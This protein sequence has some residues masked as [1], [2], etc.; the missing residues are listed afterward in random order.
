MAGILPRVGG[1]LLRRPRLRFALVAATAVVLVGGGIAAARLIGT[2]SRP[3]ASGGSDL[4][5]AVAHIGQG[6]LQ[7][8]QQVSGTVGYQGSYTIQTQ[9]SGVFTGLP[10]AGQVI[11]SGEVLYSVGS[12]SSATEAALLSAEAQLAS[13]QASL[14]QAL[15]PTAA[16]QA[17]LQA[18][19]QRVAADR[20]NI[21]NGPQAI[22]SQNDKIVADQQR[23]ATDQQDIKDLGVTSPVSGTVSVVDVSSGQQVAPGAALFQ[24]VQP[25]SIEVQ[26]SVPEIDLPN[27]YV[28]EGVE[29][30]TQDQGT[31]N[32]AVASIGFTSSGSNR[33]GALFPVT[34]TIE[35]PPS[36]M[37]AG[38]QATVSFTQSYLTEA[39]TVAFQDTQTVTAQVS[40]TVTGVLRQAGQAVQEG[41]SV[42]TLSSPQLQTQLTQ[43]ETQLSSDEAQLAS[44]RAQVTTY[45]A[46]LSSDQASLDTLE[47]PTPPSQDQVAALRARVSADQASV[48]QAQANLAQSDTPVVLLYGQTPAYRDLAQGESGQDVEELNA[49]LAADGYLSAASVTDTYG[50]ATAA[51]VRR[52]QAHLRAPQTGTLSLGDVVFLPNAVRVTTVTPSLGAAAGN[53]QT[54]LAATSD[55]PEVVAE[56]DPSLQSDVKAGD[57]VTIT[58]PDQSTVSGKVTSVAE[59]ATAGGSSSSPSIQV[60]VTPSHPAALSLLD[61][62]SVN[63]A[64]ATASVQDALYVPVTALLAERGGG[65]DVELVQPGGKRS[66]VPV[67]LGLFDDSGGLVQVSGHGIA[68]GEEVVVAGS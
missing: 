32:A 42:V 5:T 3:P 27:I 60:D 28:G 39:G 23:I 35:D 29:V 14:Q 68:A 10:V 22:A 55:T 52:L 6:A 30:W 33:Q 62:A 61:G 47:H 19:E 21:Q 7:A 12:G 4:G 53:G 25:D 8:Q 20:Q 18:D 48:L 67:T 9:L 1:P 37:R 56:I 63:V 65:Y 64:V 2:G 31:M 57:G 15:H 46:Q 11:R 38:M 24:V 58:L 45:K 41:Q 44:L 49:A 36:G 54:V 40:A 59:A 34:L 16:S 43:D 66:F 13:D 26:T 17:S 50:P 51:A